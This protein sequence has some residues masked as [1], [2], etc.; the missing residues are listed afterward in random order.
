MV[1]WS[2]CGGGERFS[3]PAAATASR[4]SRRT[5]G[6]RNRTR[7]HSR[8]QRS[9][10]THRM[11]DYQHVRAGHFVSRQPAPQ[12]A[13]QSHRFTGVNGC[14]HFELLVGEASCRHSYA[15]W[16]AG[17]AVAAAGG[18]DSILCGGRL[19]ANAMSVMETPA[20]GRYRRVQDSWR[21]CAQRCCKGCLCPRLQDIKLSNSSKK[22]R[23]SFL[24]LELIAIRS[25]VILISYR[26]FC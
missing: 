3:P 17:L 14:R 18:L 7:S 5:K 6:G 23:L 4:A 1:A 8:H 16:R 21:A 15:A 26:I 2:R 10:R 25:A 12:I 13:R 20:S 9:A 11:D 24:K 22:G 19:L